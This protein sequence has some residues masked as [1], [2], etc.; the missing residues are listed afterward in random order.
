MIPSNVPQDHLEMSPIIYGTS[1]FAQLYNPIKAHWP[2]EACKRAIDRGINTFDTSPYYGNSE[3]VLGK[4]LLSISDTHPR[5]TYYLSTKVGRYGLKKT[6]F[7]YSKERVRASVEE[8]M[9]RMHT[10]YLDI[11]FAHDVEFVSVD[12]AVEAVEELFRLKAEGK[13]KCVGIS[14]YPLPYLLALIPVIHE[15]MGQTLDILMTYCHYNLHNTLLMDYIGQFRELGIKTIWS[16]SPVSMGLLRSNTPAPDW[17]PA[18]KKLRA[19]AQ[20]C[21]QIVEQACPGKDLA[22]VAVKFGMKKQGRQ[23]GGYD[24]L[25][26]GMSNADEV[27]Q[28]VQ[29]WKEVREM[30][31]VNGGKNSKDDQQRIED[32]VRK[33]LQEFEKMEWAS[34]PID[35]C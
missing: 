7:D 16:A 22:E 9:R 19:A 6:E 21:I 30:N 27:E 28:N 32:A 20:D 13:I 14:G 18:P 15:R 35:D 4:S 11:V 17:H 8:S 12:K 3:H 24:G 25:V 2:A 5:S 23:H 33:R 26:L 1:A 29:W 34:P 10:D 31:H